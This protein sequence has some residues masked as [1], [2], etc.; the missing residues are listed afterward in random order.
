MIQVSTSTVCNGNT[1]YV[2]GFIFSK[3]RSTKPTFKSKSGEA[4]GLL[5]KLKSGEAGSLLFKSKSG[6]AGSLLLK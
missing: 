4:G 5:F 6:E 2:L 1:K 3:W